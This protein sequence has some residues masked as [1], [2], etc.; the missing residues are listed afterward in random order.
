VCHHRVIRLADRPSEPGLFANPTWLVIGVL[1]AVRVLVCVGAAQG[2]G[3]ITDTDVGRFHQIAISEGRPYRDFDVE[4][5]PVETIS[6]ELL[7]GGD[8]RAAAAR[9]AVVSLVCDL[10]A[11]GGVWYGWG[12]RAAALYL[13]IGLPLVPFIAVRLDPL[14]VALAVWG[15]ASARHGRDR[16]GGATLAVAGLTKLWPLVIAPALLIERRPR[17]AR[18]FACLFVAGIGA[19]IAYGGTDAIRQVVSFRGATGWE[20]ES[21]V[22]SIVWLLTG[23][24]VR[25]EGGAP[26]VGQIPGWSRPLLLLVLIAVLVAIWARTRGRRVDAAGAPS[27]AAVAALLALSPLFS[28]QY[29]S[30]L[31]PWAAV[32]WTDVRTARMGRIGL[33]I[34]LLTGIL[35]FL[36]NQIDPAQGGLLSVRLGVGGLL[37]LRDGLC[38][39]IAVAWLLRDPALHEPATP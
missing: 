24:P 7:A 17:A 2:I 23:G 27:L 4:Y 9:L 37:L 36:Y 3:A 21:T 6:I 22:G 35:A 29:A 19:W 34:S 38:V 30:W 16:T 13:L 25:I 5:A 11:F 28:L 26:R 8:R 33:S 18:W 15:L 10:L 12:R 39:W 20:I 14:V 1:V 32:A 31:A